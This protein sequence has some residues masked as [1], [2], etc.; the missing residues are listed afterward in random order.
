MWRRVTR[1]LVLAVLATLLTSSAF[2]QAQTISALDF[3]DPSVTQSGVVL[4]KGWALD[5]RAI[6]KAELYVDD[7]F[8][9]PLI[10]GL[11][12]IDVEQIYPNWPGIH[13]VAPGFQTGFL[14]SRF[15]NGPHTVAVKLTFSDGQVIELGRRAINIDNT[16]NQPPFGNVDLPDASGIYNASGSFPVVGWAADT[17][18]IARVELLVDGA[19]MQG[20]VY[21][22]AR[23]DVGNSFPD[24][25]AALFS[26]FIANMDATR[27]AEGVHLLEIR[28]VDNQGAQRL[29]GRRQIQG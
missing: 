28:A 20:A 14:A 23:P 13:N 7:T 4:V 10:T 22:D 17:D 19:V 8:Q 15:T 24:F 25:P 16:L 18:G 12:R 29:I 11:P 9:Y 26:G 2:A 1:G 5:P 27:L 6:S 3:P 21:G